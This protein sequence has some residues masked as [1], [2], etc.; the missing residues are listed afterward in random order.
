MRPHIEL[1]GALAAEESI[2]R[3][4][5]DQTDYFHRR[6][7]L[8]YVCRVADSLLT[9]PDPQHRSSSALLVR[10]GIPLLLRMTVAV[11]PTVVGCPVP[12]TQP[13]HLEF[14]FDLLRRAGAIQFARQYLELNR[15][16][17]VR[18]VRRG[19]DFSF[20]ANTTLEG[21]EAIDVGDWRELMRVRRQ[22][23]EAATEDSARRWPAVRKQMSELVRPGDGWA[24]EYDAAP[25]VDRYFEQRAVYE[26]GTSFGHDELPEDSEFGGFR[27]ETIR[28][29]IVS[30]IGIARKHLAFCNL[31]ME[32]HP[33]IKRENITTITKDIPDALETIQGV[34]GLGI[35]FARMFLRLGTLSPE[36]LRRQT[37]TPGETPSPLFIHAGTS[38]LLVP[39]YGRLINPFEFVFRELRATFRRDWDRAM[40]GREAD[41]R[42]DLRRL[43][44]NQHVL[45]ADTGFKVRA[46]GRLLT[47]V[48]ATAFD[49]RS[50]DLVLFQLKW[51]DGYGND[52]RARRSKA[53][54]LVKG[55]NNWVAVVHQW[56][57]GNNTALR[58]GAGIPANSCP[59][60]R[61]HLVV[62][63]RHTIRFSG[64]IEDYDPRAV[65][66]T[67]ARLSNLWRELR[68]VAAPLK[69][70]GG[71]RRGRSW[72]SQLGR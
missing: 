30:H 17:R 37:A 41:F 15:Q 20:H 48:D 31:L 28:D 65:W 40:D 46:G 44:A 2:I 61:I 47:D 33:E 21:H 64:F 62:L 3:R 45:V 71:S 18:L 22:R 42:A 70:A 14:H 23:V 56:V 50:G 69:T 19:S 39:A 25:E 34:S 32:A 58:A 63:T 6:F 36:N 55:A 5:L 67:W 4:F 60:A 66:L 26:A 38:Q 24:I 9:E 13:G 59:I 27:W 16:K 68:D 1:R 11:G 10:A 52:M 53:T 54:N 12:A 49:T 29:A 72:S 8:V 51:Q 35:D 43:L 57:Q 7:P